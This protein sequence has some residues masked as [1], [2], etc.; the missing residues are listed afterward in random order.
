[1]TLSSSEKMWKAEEDN[2]VEEEGKHADEE[3]E[4]N[5]KNN[6]KKRNSPGP[7]FYGR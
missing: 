3:T 6:N 2:E 5:K 7:L 4:L 1:M